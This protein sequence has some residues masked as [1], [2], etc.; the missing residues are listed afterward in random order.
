MIKIEIDDRKF[1][2]EMEELIRRVTDRR[3]LMRQIAGIMH[4]AVEENFAEQGRPRWL[5]LSPKTIAMRQ[6]KGYWPGKILQMRGELAASIT[7]QSDND[8][9]IV[10]TNKVY[11]AIHQFGGKAGRGKKVDIPAR[12]FLKLTD[13]DLE[14]IKRAVVEYLKGGG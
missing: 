6:K 1:K 10:G 13:E 2:A 3:A 14:E 9:A 12:P 5:P 11:A 4:Y 8:S 7:Q